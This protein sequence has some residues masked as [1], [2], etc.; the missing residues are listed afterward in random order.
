MRKILLIAASLLMT[1]SMMAA[2]NNSGST[3]ANAIDFDWTNGNVHESSKA[4]WYR[5]DMSNL[6]GMID[7][8]LALYLTNLTDQNAQVDVTVTATVTIMGQSQTETQD[9]SYKLNPKDYKIF[10]KNVK[11]LLDF[12]VKY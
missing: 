12:N 10:S 6:T 7:P 3:K 5:V 4:L 9:L 2:G 11:Q 1:I 8:T